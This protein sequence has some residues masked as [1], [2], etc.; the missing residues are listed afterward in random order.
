MR[1]QGQELHLGL[2][3]TPWLAA[4]AFNVASEMI[5]RGA[6]PPNEIPGP[7]QP[8]VEQV[9]A[10]TEFVRKRLGLSPRVKKTIQEMPSE[11][12]L[13][14]FFEITVIGFWRLQAASDASEASRSRAAWRIAEASRLLFR[15]PH[16]PSPHEAMTALLTRR[17][18][19]EFRD[20]ALAR[21]I[22]LDDGDDE[23]RVASWLVL[24]DES[25]VIRSFREEVQDR[26]PDFFGAIPHS[27]PNWLQVLG[28][29]IPFTAEQLRDAYR[30]RSRTAHPDA[31]GAPEEF[32]RL[33]ASYERARSYL[34]GQ[35]E[36]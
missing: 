27:A 2:Y 23:L 36:E 11:A 30:V 21:E 5:G 35:R 3:E 33:N 29:A 34:R 6:R 13:L 15:D 16:L 4:F 28:L 7:Q 9:H 26:Y 32:I 8:T 10:I 24:P 18:A 31:G 14:A 12:D 22:L 17:L 20:Q 19:S 25:N 1:H